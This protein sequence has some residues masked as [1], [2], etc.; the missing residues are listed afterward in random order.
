MLWVFKTSAFPYPPRRVGRRWIRFGLPAIL[1]WGL[2]AVPGGTIPSSVP[3]PGV[4]A[5]GVEAPAEEWAEIPSDL[6][7]LL[8]QIED[9]ADDDPERAL[10]YGNE[11]LKRLAEEPRPDLRRGLLYRL[12][13]IAYH[14]E[15]H[16]VAAE[17]CADGEVLA[18]EVGS[19][20]HLAN[21]LRLKGNVVRR[22][23]RHHEAL[24]ASSEARDIYRRLG[25]WRGYAAACNGVGYAH[26]RMGRYAEALDAYLEAYDAF[27]RVDD[28]KGMGWSLRNIGTLHVDVG[29]L[30]EG[31]RIYLQALEIQQAVGSR[32][33]TRAVLSSLGNVQRLLGDPRTA[34]ETQ[35]RALKMEEEADDRTGTAVV[36]G[37]IGDTY[38]DL[39]D[40]DLAL[41]YYAQSLARRRE[42]GDRH[43]ESLQLLTIAELLQSL[44]RH[45]EALQH[46]SDA[47]AIAQ[48]IDTQAELAAAHRISAAS[49][50]A[51]GCPDEAAA[52]LDA[53]HRTA[54]VLSSPEE[55][56]ALVESRLRFQSRF[57]S[58]QLK[59]LQ[60]RFEGAAQ[61][62][63][64]LWIAVWLLPLVGLV[65]GLGLGRA[66]RRRRQE[67]GLPA[68]VLADADGA[69]RP[70][71]TDLAERRAWDGPTLP[72][73]EVVETAPTEDCAGPTAAAVT[74]AA[75]TTDAAAP[76]GR[77]A[78][79][80]I[81]EPEVEA[82]P[83]VPPG[84]VFPTGFY[85][86][87]SPAVRR[88]YV[89]MEPLLDGASSVL[90]EGETGVGK[91][92]IAH[93]LHQ[94]S[95]R[96][97]APFVVVNCA[98]IP[99]DLLEAELFGI[100]RGVATGVTARSGHFR[101]AAGGTLL[102]DEIGEMPLP[103]QAKL[104]R[105]VQEKKV[106]P[107]GGRE[108]DVDTWILAATNRQLA[109][110]VEEGSF[111]RDLYYRLAV[112]VLAV[113][114]LR[115]RP[116]D[117]VPLFLHFLTAKRPPDA[118][119][120]EI[121]AA[122][123]SRLARHPWPGNIRQLENLASRVTRALGDDDKVSAEHLGDL[124]AAPVR[125]GAGETE[126]LDS[127]RLRDHVQAMEKRL[128]LAALEEVGGS[129]RKVASLLE[130][131]R[132]TLARKMS[133]LDLDP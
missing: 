67:G 40:L 106:Q 47:L 119:T 55:Q 93:I 127:W 36:L 10:F 120:V 11:A 62:T 3:V 52:A 105:V 82:A 56:S 100:G 95:A 96:R 18:R 6:L 43:R 46:A 48:A 59:N 53:A 122:A 89:A 131:S 28:A 15:R 77:D 32:S 61:T 68:S 74:D 35:L 102:L 65:L 27:E 45:D 114:P 109:H 21:I 7:Q 16:E 84:L 90:I 70:E 17:L 126:A 94:S 73:L 76:A 92:R 124:S 75:A 129:R 39:G 13:R 57:Q 104:L 69:S 103:L 20:P 5:P 118:A 9:A 23:G 85:V 132:S 30:E 1:F 33:E 37:F 54:A 99:A 51:L 98:A 14:R 29:E 24:E 25:N 22:L 8:G 79:A 58:W 12:C 81:V 113:P 125:H 19:A 86:G 112:D 26:W 50:D 38:R 107:L 49:F 88:L 91:E 44:D 97:A 72:E 63:R 64:R 4:E 101:A 123:A 130:I 111:R 110:Q 42:T 2:V 66:W 121:E 41:D 133:E 80:G 31:R 83:D 34:L 78:A 128:I 60:Q 87:V 117:A 116:D 108:E 115:D 71:P